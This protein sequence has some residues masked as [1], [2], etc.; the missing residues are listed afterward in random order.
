MIAF[1]MANEYQQSFERLRR[2]LLVEDDSDLSYAMKIMLESFGLGGIAA[3]HTAEEALKH[4][5]TPFDLLITDFDLP[6]MD[7]VS[8]LEECRARH[9][10]IP[11]IFMSGRPEL[12]P[13][14]KIAL[15]DCCATLMR[16][17]PNLHVLEQALHAAD[18]RVHH[19]DCVHRRTIPVR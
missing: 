18:A 17:P 12:V 19:T 5:H 7:G 9:L 3:V 8:L 6:G 1:N 4:L 11:V 16:K 10:H 15:E 13:R 14:E 2:V